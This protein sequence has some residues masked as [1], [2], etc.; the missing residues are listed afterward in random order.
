MKRK[1][2][3]NPSLA[4][5]LVWVQPVTRE[6]AC[7]PPSRRRSPVPANLG[8]SRMLASLIVVA[9]KPAGAACAIS[10][11]AA[12]SQGVLPSNT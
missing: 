8:R 6:R 2:R 4:G 1:S 10:I 5:K 12:V 9:V 3:E 11:R 7:C